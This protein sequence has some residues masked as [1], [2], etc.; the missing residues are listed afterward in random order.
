[1]V[2][3]ILYGITLNMG[4]IVILEWRHFNNQGGALLLFLSLIIVLCRKEEAEEYVID[5]RML[6]GPHIFPLKILCE[7]VPIQSKKR[8]V[9]SGN[10]TQEDTDSSR[11][12]SVNHFNE[13]SG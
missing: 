9:D 6:S 4:E 11:P 12:S 1:M 3:C 2:A 5:T 7:G 8:K 13:I 10:S